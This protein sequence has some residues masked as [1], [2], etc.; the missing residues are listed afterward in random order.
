MKGTQFG[1]TYLAKSKNETKFD[2]VLLDAIDT[3]FS[4]LGQNVKFSIYFNLEAKF[5]LPKQDIPDRI[6]DFSDALDKIFG[7]AARSLEI[8]IMKYLSDKVKCNYSWVGPKWLVPDLTFEKYIKLVRI[9]VQDS[10]R[11]GEV[12]VLFD[13]YQRPEQET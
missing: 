5:G 6:S 12:E 1:M 3:A 10:G 9:S 8:L 2:K 11:P 7:Q 4:A 13:G